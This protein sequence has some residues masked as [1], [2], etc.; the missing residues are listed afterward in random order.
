MN[1]LKNKIVTIK[2]IREILML[3]DSHTCICMNDND[4]LTLIFY[5]H[6]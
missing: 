6:F 4:T 1:G 2:D 3:L 5:I